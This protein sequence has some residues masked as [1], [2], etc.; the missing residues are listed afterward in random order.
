MR[1]MLIEPDCCVT[2][3][4]YV[5]CKKCGLTGP[6]LHQIRKLLPATD[7]YVKEQFPQ[8]TGYGAVAQRV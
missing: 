4:K 8:W 5:R 3:S 6:E 7:E 2:E 1:V